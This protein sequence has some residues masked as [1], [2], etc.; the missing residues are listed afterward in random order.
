MT[1]EWENCVRCQSPRVVPGGIA[2]PL[3]ATTFVI[4]SHIADRPAFFS[5]NHK[6]ELEPIAWLCLECGLAWQAAKAENL[7][8]VLTSIREKCR[9]EFRDKLF[10]E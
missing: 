1:T 7:E 4:D 10:G 3:G 9:P 5:A 2:D 8:E 6:V